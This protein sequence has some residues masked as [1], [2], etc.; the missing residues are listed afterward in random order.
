[1]AHPTKRRRASAADEARE[2]EVI[3]SALAEGRPSPQPRAAHEPQQ[4]DVHRSGAEHE[5]V[6]RLDDGPAT[7]FNPTW[8]GDERGEVM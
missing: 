8:R 1:M 3:S 5:E 4:A 6:R 7:D 2:R